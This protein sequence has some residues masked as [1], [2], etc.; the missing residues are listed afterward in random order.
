MSILWQQL[1][2]S[3][4]STLYNHLQ[5]VMSE[6]LHFYFLPSMRDTYLLKTDVTVAESCVFL[7]FGQVE[8]LYPE[9]TDNI[10]KK[11]ISI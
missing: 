11:Q 2:S 3:N 10:W 4:S 9:D 5:N 7:F 8:S 6:L 1:V